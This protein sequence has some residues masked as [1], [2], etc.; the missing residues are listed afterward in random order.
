MSLLSFLGRYLGSHGTNARIALGQAGLL[1]SLIL[2]ASMLGL[3]P[4][5]DAALRKSY[6]ALAEAIAANSSVFLTRS[7]IRRMKANLGVIVRAF[8]E[9]FRLRKEIRRTT[10]PAPGDR[11]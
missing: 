3:L 4:D 7:D 5:R 11:K 8:R 10:N 6:T 9:L 1:V 2:T